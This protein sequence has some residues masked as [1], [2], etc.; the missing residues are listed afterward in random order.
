MDVVMPPVFDN[1]DM[2][3]DSIE[4][5]FSKYQPD[6]L[7]ICLGQNDGVQDSTAFCGRVKASFYRGICGALSASGNSA[8]D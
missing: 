5:D 7:T 6:V 1:V 8:L 3:Y 4:W 2:R